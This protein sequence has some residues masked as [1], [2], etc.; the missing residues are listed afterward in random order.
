MFR[1]LRLLILTK[2]IKITPNNRIAP[3]FHSIVIGKA[4]KHTLDCTLNT[5]LFYPFFVVMS[6]NVAGA[7]AIGNAEANDAEEEQLIADDADL[8]KLVTILKKPGTP[9]QELFSSFELVSTVLEADESPPMREAIDAGLLEVLISMLSKTQS[10]WIFDILSGKTPLAGNGDAN[11][12]HKLATA[13]VWLPA[14]LE[15]VVTEM[16]CQAAWVTGKVVMG[17]FLKEAMEHGLLEALAK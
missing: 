16:K 6:T 5:F 8:S 9:I 10:D 17:G 4:T 1:L 3:S 7:E 14:F 12:C 13:S 2:S 11:S 15:Q